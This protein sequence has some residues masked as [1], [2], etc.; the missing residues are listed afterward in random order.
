M[1]LIKTKIIKEQSVIIPGSKSISHRVL[2]CASLC[3]GVSVLHNLLQSEDISLTMNAL[4][5][6]GVLFEKSSDNILLVH[7]FK[8]GYPEKFTKP[9]YLGNS[10]TS[11]RLLASIAS[12]GKTKYTLTGDKRLKERPIK[13][14]LDALSYLGN[15]AESQNKNGTAPIDIQGKNRNGGKLTIDC[16][17]SSQYL[18]SLLMV[19]PLMEK[20]LDINLVK[21]PVS[22]PYIDLTIDIMKKFDVKVNKISSTHF[23]VSGQKAYSP[24]HIFVEPDISN[25]GYFWGVGAITGKMVSVLNINK[26]SHQGDL[27]QIELF[28]QMGCKIKVAKN[29]IGVCGRSLKGIET[30]MSDIPDAVP[31]IAVVAAFAKGKTKITNIG[32]LRG[33]ECDRIDAIASGLK[34][35]GIKT[36]TGDDYI[37]ITGGKPK[38][39]EI[40]TFNDHRIAMAFSI[41]GLLIENIRIENEYCVEKSFPNFWE[42]FNSL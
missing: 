16:S 30:D 3:Q 42:V 4:S 26:K 21:G 38:G 36:K 24:Q 27:R 8:K 33:K 14:L 5:K 20:G 22:S 39:N 10:G 25:A 12:L 34:S 28:K 32:H 37:I 40:K 6:M 35:M 11:L 7:G 9:I 19:G 15:L 31:V 13:E 23:K 17:K 1:K 18:S 29:K 2:I 41:T